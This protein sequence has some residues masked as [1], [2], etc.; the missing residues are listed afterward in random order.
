MIANE[1]VVSVEHPSLGPLRV[2]GV[3]VKLSETPGHVRSVAPELGQHTE[4]VL[5]MLG[6]DWEQIGGLRERGVI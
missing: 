4:E 3:P 5:L 1:Y 6:Y 2:P